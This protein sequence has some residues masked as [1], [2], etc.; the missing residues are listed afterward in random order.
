MQ[1]N[2]NAAPA[3]GDVVSPHMTGA[4]VDIPK[5]N[6]SRA[7]MAWMRRHLLAIEADGK[8]DVEE[9][10]QQSCF[11]I[12]VYK[13]YL[14]TYHPIPRHTQAPSQAHTGGAKGRTVHAPVA[15]GPP[16]QGL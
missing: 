10:F 3:E 7:E 5:D 9:E 13:N 6:L 15:D 11:H 12:T 2:G 16:A 4:A 8:I 1:V 14:P